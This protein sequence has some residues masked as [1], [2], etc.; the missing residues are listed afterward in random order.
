M[1]RKL[2]SSLFCAVV[3]SLLPNCGSKVAEFIGASCD[4]L[5]IG[6]GQ[7]PDI[8]LGCAS[9]SILMSHIATV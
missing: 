7:W 8:D 3:S 6:S 4:R 2:L 5:T 9:R 1:I